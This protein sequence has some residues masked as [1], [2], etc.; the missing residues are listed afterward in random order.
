MY[1]RAN[2]GQKHSN[3]SVLNFLQ[4]TFNAAAGNNHQVLDIGCGPGDFTRDDL[5]PRCMPC[6]R[7][8]ATDVS[9]DMLD[10]AMTHN[11]HA[12]IQ[13]EFLDIGGDVSDF[14]SKHGQFE[15]VYSFQC[16]HWTNQKAAFENI[17]RLLA[18]G[19]ECLLHYPARTSSF[20]WWREIAQIE[21]WSKYREVSGMF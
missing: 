1:A 2:K 12:K 9:R 17:A 7:I 18:P 5:L 4:E 11:A 13:Y 21:R 8:V 16:L 10:F 15:R 6:R 20:Q 19:G 14:L 3:R